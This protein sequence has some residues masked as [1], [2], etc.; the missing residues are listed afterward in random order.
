MASASFV[1]SDLLGKKIKLMTRLLGL[2]LEAT[3]EPGQVSGLSE[4]DDDQSIV[5]RR[6]RDRAMYSCESSR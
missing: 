6:Y 5:P 4:Q 1:M 2:L 3:T